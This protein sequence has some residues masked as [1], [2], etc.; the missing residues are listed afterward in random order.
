MSLTGLTLQPV[1]TFLSLAV[2]ELEPF[3]QVPWR[4]WNKMV[5]APKKRT[6]DA[7]RKETNLS[8]GA[9]VKAFELGYYFD[10]AG[11]SFAEKKQGTEE[12]INS[13]STGGD[14]TLLWSY[15]ETLR[16]SGS[17]KLLPWIPRRSVRFRIF[18]DFGLE[19]SLTV[20]PVEY[21]LQPQ[22]QLRDHQVL[23]A[24]GACAPAGMITC[25]M[26]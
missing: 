5:Q 24:I 25:C 9:W 13:F 14:T 19:L 10:W 22:P 3:Q 23:H 6:D 12:F 21:V 20:D 18:D 26:M 17:F 7:V 16:P 4:S 1:S 8:K 11:G 15:D 2:M